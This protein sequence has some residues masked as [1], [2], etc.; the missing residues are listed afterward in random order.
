MCRCQPCCQI[1]LNNTCCWPKTWGTEAW[2][3]FAS[4]MAIQWGCTPRRFSRTGP[5]W[6]AKFQAVRHSQFMTPG[7]VG[8]GG[9][10]WKKLMAPDLA[11]NNG[12]ET[13]GTKAFT[14]ID[15]IQ[16]SHFFRCFFHVY[17]FYHFRETKAILGCTILSIQKASFSPPILTQ[18]SRGPRASGLRLLRVQTVW[19]GPV[20]PKTSFGK[21]R[22]VGNLVFDGSTIHGKTGPVQSLFIILKRK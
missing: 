9:E 22:R 5:P 8:K 12:Y 1:L 17:I 6:L 13:C 3:P 20:G 7:A 14:T 18:E 4:P 15:K 16:N 2:L 19:L 11:K 21:L 10:P